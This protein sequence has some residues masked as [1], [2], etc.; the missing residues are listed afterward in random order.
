MARREANPFDLIINVPP[1]T[2]KSSIC[3]V[4]FP[5]WCWTKWPWM[6]FLT[7]S[8]NQQV[9]IK[10]A[11]A[12][13]KVIES[14]Q[15]RMVYP[16]IRLRKGKEGVT[17]YEISTLGPHGWVPTGGGRFSSSVGG[18]GTAFHGDILIPDDPLNAEQSFSP[19]ELMVTNRWVDQTLPTRKT[20]KEV[21]ATIW[22]QQRLHEIDPSGH[23]LAKMK[24]GKLRIKHICL[25]ADISTTDG[26][27]N[28]MYARLVSPPELKAHYI[29]GLLDPVRLPRHVINDLEAQLGQYGAAAQLGQ[30]PSPPSGGMFKTDRFIVVDRMPPDVSIIRTVRFWDKACLVAGTVIATARGPVC[31][32]QIKEGDLVLTRMGYRRVRKAW[33]SKYTNELTSVIFSNGAVLTGTPDHPVYS[34][35]SNWPGLADLTECDTMIG[36]KEGIWEGQGITMQTLSSS[37]AAGMSGSQ[38]ADISTAMILRRGGIDHSTGIS[39]NFI[40][41]PYPLAII[42]T[43]RTRTGTTTT[44]RILN[45]SPLRSTGLFTRM[46]SRL[47]LLWQTRLIGLR[48]LKLFWQECKSPR[49]TIVRIVAGSFLRR[50]SRQNIAPPV[51]EHVTESQTGIP[52]YDLMV[53]GRP[54]FF[55]N[56][57][58]VHNSTDPTKEKN[59][60]P[61]YTVGTKMSLL[62]N[63]KYIVSDVVR[64][65]WMAEDREDMILAVAQADGHEVEIWTEQE[66]GSGGKESAEATVRNLA[67]FSIRAERPVGNKVARADTFSVQV[68]RYNVMLLQAAWNQEFKSEYSYFPN[69]K[70]KDQVDSGAGAFTKLAQRKEVWVGQRR[71][72]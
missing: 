66:P 10:S 21:S 3:S 63:G 7:F 16:D 19:Q 15:F 36:L 25:P 48:H 60:E 67:G 40:T 27:G 9:A 51:R 4:M 39:G 72:R 22:I 45:V 68:N 31:I 17:D 70:F 69:S 42:S 64:G 12:S 55:A 49:S 58:L 59:Q 1:G 18:S 33:L 8:Y 57:I 32:E 56:G 5:V 52:A 43:T 65:R 61:A 29:D 44:Y 23:L 50:V 2:S 38:E 28:V 11:D 35:C 46:I 13:K 62:V 54:E 53:E 41:A 14:R 24:A 26:D 6:R 20:N 30:N 71:G 34:D 47:R 37:M